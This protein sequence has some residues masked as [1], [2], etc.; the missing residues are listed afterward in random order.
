MKTLLA[1][2]LSTVPAL[3]EMPPASMDLGS[4]S[5]SEAQVIGVY[6]EHFGH[7]RFDSVRLVR[8]PNGSAWLHCF[9]PAK[10]PM[11]GCDLEMESGEHV[12]VYSFDP[13]GA[14]PYMANNVL[15]HEFAHEF[16][17][18]PANHPHARP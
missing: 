2:L 8:V 16:F 15:R 12:V 17:H 10:C 6:R 5:M 3:A 14:D 7:A 9:E 4:H 18:W 1:F 13:T 11:F